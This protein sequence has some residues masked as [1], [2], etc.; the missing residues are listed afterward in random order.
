M[1]PAVTYGN[2]NRNSELDIMKR[3]WNL[4]AIRPKRH[5]FIKSLP[6]D[7]REPCLKKRQR[8]CRSQWRWCTSRV[9]GL[10]NHYD[11]WTHRD[12]G[13]K[14]WV[15]MA[16]YQILCVSIMASLVYWFIEF[17][18]V[19]SRSLITVPFLSSFGSVCFLFCSILMFYLSTILL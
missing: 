8:N 9:Q 18:S 12:S 19:E 13:S 7:L 15:W 11:Q 2:T 3:V 16:L 5:V 4:R 6:S 17:L 10:V 1:L 14:H